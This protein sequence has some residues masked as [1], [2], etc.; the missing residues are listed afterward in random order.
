VL[1]VVCQMATLAPVAQVLEVAVLRRVV[2]V[3]SSQHDDGARDRM[4][5]AVLCPTVWI[6]R[7]SLAAIAGTLSHLGDDLAPVLRITV[8]VFRS[9]RHGLH[10]SDQITATR[11]TR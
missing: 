7:R 6:G 8:A 10:P 3:R 4:R 11:R 9:D 2:Q 1:T 5:L